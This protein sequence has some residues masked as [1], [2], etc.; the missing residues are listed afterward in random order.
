MRP[1]LT[2]SASWPGVKSAALVTTP[3]GPICRSASV[4]AAAAPLGGRRPQEALEVVLPLVQHRE[5]S[6]L[7]AE[8]VPVVH[9]EIAIGASRH[10]AR[11]ERRLLELLGHGRDVPT[12]TG[13]G[14]VRV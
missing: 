3:P 10:R 1:E 6:P 13:A 2:A 11:A 12:R 4:G 7:R 9:H 5:G 14:R 8:K